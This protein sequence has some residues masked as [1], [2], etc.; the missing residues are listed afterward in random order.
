MN[1]SYLPFVLVLFLVLSCRKDSS[2][3]Q[4]G[5]SGNEHSYSIKEAKVFLKKDVGVKGGKVT[6][7]QN[8]SLTK[9]ANL[10]IEAHVFWKKAI[11]YDLRSYGVVE[12]P[13]LE[14]NKRVTLY[15]FAT[16]ERNRDYDKL[17][18]EASFTNLLIYRNLTGDES[19]AFVTYIPD[20]SYVQ[21][22]GSSARHST[23]KNIDKN[24]YGYIE[25][26]NW[27]GDVLFVLRIQA[28]SV[29][30]RFRIGNS[31]DSKLSA[32]KASNGASS[33]TSCRTVCTPIYETICAGPTE[34]IGEEQCVSHQI[35]ENC[36]TVCDDGGGGETDPPTPPDGGGQPGHNDNPQVQE[37]VNRI[38]DMANVCDA[39]KP[40]ISKLVEEVGA[41]T[42]TSYGQN[43][44]RCFNL[45]VLKSL[46]SD[47][48]AKRI[49]ICIDST[50]NPNARYNSGS[51]SLTF[52]TVYTLDARVI[53]E[54][55]FHALQDRVHPG[56]TSKYAQPSNGLAGLSDI[57]FEY[58]FYRDL[59]IRMDGQIP[60]ASDSDSYK[61]FMDELTRNGTTFPELI[62]VT[63]YFGNKYKTFLE[64]FK[65]KYSNSGYDKPTLNINPE[66]LV[67][68]LEHNDCTN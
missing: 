53:Q 39:F 5:T 12:V 1:K 48:P 7:S 68:M 62:D 18:T 65:K 46:E 23:L 45:A 10:K 42:S 36:Y 52:G 9:R 63:Q 21:S 61:T 30:N 56:G 15:D 19:K 25:Y 51:K 57:E 31:S 43:Y 67:Y 16:P 20:K 17:R 14:N 38:F 33:T 8:N 2:E 50:S 44:T 29:I 49:K 24:F 35:G 34:G 13:F 60:F 66:A 37:T 3:L 47:D 6:L 32:M 58:A 55:L 27:E 54:E 4:Y 40:Y 64:E 11:E 59:I 26:K 41:L 28:G 22:F